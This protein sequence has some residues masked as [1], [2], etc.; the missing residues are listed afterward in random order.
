MQVKPVESVGGF[1]FAFFV[2]RMA[3][4]VYYWLIIDDLLP[5]SNLREKGKYA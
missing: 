4:Q 3:Y 5:E 2:D 1:V